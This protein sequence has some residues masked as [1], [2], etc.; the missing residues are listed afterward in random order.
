MHYGLNSLPMCVCLWWCNGSDLETI[1]GPLS[2]FF[3]LQTLCVYF[4]LTLSLNIAPLGKHT[5]THTQ[6][7]THKSFD[8][9]KPQTATMHHCLG[10]RAFPDMV[11][12]SVD[13][14][15]TPF[16]HSNVSYSPYSLSAFVFLSISCTKHTQETTLF[17]CC[18]LEFLSLFHLYF[19]CLFSFSLFFHSPLTFFPR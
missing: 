18:I 8:T 14:S 4:T 15:V 10:L 6:T 1:I 2:L 19:P 7:H 13:T 5:H 3:I 11:P 12:S 16:C 9:Q 17:C